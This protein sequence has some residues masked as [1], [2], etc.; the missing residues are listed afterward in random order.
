MNEIRPTIGIEFNDKYIYAKNKL[1]ESYK[2]FKQLNE[3]QKQ[4]LAIEFL[5]SVGMPDAFEQF[6]RY[7]N[8]GGRF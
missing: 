8:N 7:I 4:Q 3:A 1:F 5:N 2:A 6:V